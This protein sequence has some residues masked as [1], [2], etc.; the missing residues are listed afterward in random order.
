M[1]F[2]I[3]ALFLCLSFSFAINEVVLSLPAYFC[4]CVLLELFSSGICLWVSLELWLY[5][6][7]YSLC[8]A[9]DCLSID[10]NIPSIANGLFFKKSFIHTQLYDCRGIRRILLHRVLTYVLLTEFHPI[11]LMELILIKGYVSS[12]TCLFHL[13][14]LVFVPNFNFKDN[15]PLK[16]S[17]LI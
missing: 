6:V 2:Y 3:H 17:F 11:L 5:G 13:L 12:I 15:F 1:L 10:R 7:C 4:V 8:A 9:S 14:V 16:K